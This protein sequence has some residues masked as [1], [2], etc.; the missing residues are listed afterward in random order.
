[1]GDRGTTSRGEE[2]IEWA[3]RSTASFGLLVTALRAGAAQQGEACLS[4]GRFSQTL[5][6]NHLILTRVRSLAEATFS[7]A[8]KVSVSSRHPP[9]K[10]HPAARTANA[11]QASGL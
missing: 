8:E 1:M 11:V 6:S 7:E 4:S 5:A 3:A 10:P 2:K 9:G